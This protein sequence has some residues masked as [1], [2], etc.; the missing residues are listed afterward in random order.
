MALA[1][2]IFS[3]YLVLNMV[4]ATKQQ[5]IYIYN[6]GRLETE[7]MPDNTLLQYTYDPNGNLTKRTKAISFKPY[8]LSSTA[9]SYDIYL[10]N[11]PESISS[12]LFP[13]WTLQNDQDDIE[14]ISGEKV[15]NGTWK[16]TVVLDRHNKE[17]G[18]YMTHVYA[19]GK[20]VDA[21]SAEIKDSQTILAPSEASLA[22]GYYEVSVDGVA[23]TTQEVR[24]P[25]WTVSNGQDDLE[26]PWIM[27]EKIDD[28]TWRIRV[29]FS[30]HNFETGSYVTDIYSYDKY[31]N[32]SGIGG[33]TVQVT[34]G[35]GGSSET[36]ISG[37]SY[38]VFMYGVDSQ[39]QRVQFPTWTLDKGQ[40]DIDWIEGVKVANGVWRATVV[41]SKHNSETGNYVSHI[42]A[43][44][45]FVGDWGFTVTNNAAIQAPTIANLGSLYYDI[46]V[47]GIPSNVTE[48][49]FPTWTDLNGHDDIQW[50]SGE[51]ISSNSW[52]VR[53]PF[54]QHNNEIG[55]YVT[56]VYTYDA[57]G[58][59]RVVGGTVVNVTK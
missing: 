4:A 5:T 47:T 16:G 31:G 19:D 39:V 43:D 55:T 53:T 20:Y 51:R 38:D 57:Y 7:I 41:Y 59:Q 50:S 28:T 6:Q 36:D 48:V 8:I 58:N 24:F 3:D 29:P 46:T 22:D 17:T 42:Y 52:R 15:G 33:V 30:K 13:T 44:G 35:A 18:I 26:N 40:D 45:K 49:K 27:G 23:R 54:Y 1:K 14:W 56:H 10:K 9:L 11:V 25:S 34:R 37:V 32:S 21:I 12:V 2:D